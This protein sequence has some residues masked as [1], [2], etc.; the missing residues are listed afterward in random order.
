MQFPMG[1]KIVPNF[2]KLNDLKLNVLEF[3]SCNAFLTKYVNRKFYKQQIDL[4]LYK[5]QH[6]SLTDLHNFVR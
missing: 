6:C 1:T 2:E 5:N 3:K 4:L